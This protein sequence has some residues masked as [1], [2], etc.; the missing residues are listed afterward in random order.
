MGDRPQQRGF[1]NCSLALMEEDALA[2]PVRP[3]LPNGVPEGNLIYFLPEPSK[4]RFAGFPLEISTP[5]ATKT[6]DATEIVV[7]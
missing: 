6:G 4:G 1:H 3:V 7:I 5:I 2:Q